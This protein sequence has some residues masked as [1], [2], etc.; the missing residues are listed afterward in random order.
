MTV[1]IASLITTELTVNWNRAVRKSQYFDGRWIVLNYSCDSFGMDETIFWSWYCFHVLPIPSR[2]SSQT[3]HGFQKNG[4]TMIRFKKQ[5]S[6]R[7]IRV[8]VTQSLLD[9]SGM[10]YSCDSYFRFFLNSSHA[11]MRPLFGVQLL[12]TFSSDL[13]VAK[14][15]T[16]LC[17]KRKVGVPCTVPGR[18]VVSSAC[19]L[20]LAIFSNQQITAECIIWLL[21]FTD[22]VYKKC[23]A[24]KSVL[25]SLTVGHAS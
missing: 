3:Q 21:F 14:Y 24:Y 13:Q 16:C 12:N 20:L 17:N 11:Y 5:E 7:I 9:S 1:R 22:W 8:H 25:S 19:L 2:I 10:L 18:L 6:F 15:I 23:T 4:M